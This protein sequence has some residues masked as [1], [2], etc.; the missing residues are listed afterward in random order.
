MRGTV[1]RNHLG[2]P[3]V[4]ALVLAAAVVTQA[5]IQ[6]FRHRH[7][8]MPIV[9]GPGVTR[10]GLLSEYCPGLENTP[11]DTLV[12]TFEGKEPGGKLLVMGNTHSNEPAALLTAV[13]LIENAVVEKGTLIVIPQFNHS[14]SRNTRPG[15]GYPL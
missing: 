4:L 2:L 13:I 6:L 5:G 15:D 7:F 12:F 8:Q 11:A 10:I 1:D 3:K 9:A 14:G